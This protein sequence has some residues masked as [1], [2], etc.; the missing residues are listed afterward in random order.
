[1]SALAASDEDIK[2]ML[3]AQVHIGKRVCESAMDEYVFKR[4][5]TGQHIFNLAKTWEKLML[6]AR[7]LVAVENPEDICLVASPVGYA[8]RASY[9]FSQA[10]HSRMVSSRFTAGTFTNQ[11]QKRNFMEPRV[12]VV[13][14]PRMDAQ[15]IR[16]A[17]YVNLPVIAFCDTDA[18]CR[19]VDIV[20]PCNNKG[21]NSIALMYWFLAREVLRMRNVIMRSEPWDLMVDLFIY[22]HPDEI[23]KKQQQDEAAALEEKAAAPAALEYDATPAADATFAAAPV[24]DATAAPV[25]V[26]APVAGGD[27]WAPIADTF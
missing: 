11:M 5:S 18:T 17:Q 27:T 8:Q 3:A 20:I 19:G 10:T 2:L 21:K 25:A 26:A 14:D 4:S 24:A 15:P 12:L 16:E 13:S 9:K 7:V 23:K 6:A 22:K 1:M